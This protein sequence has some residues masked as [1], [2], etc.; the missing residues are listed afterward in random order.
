MLVLLSDGSDVSIF[1]QDI[2]STNIKTTENNMFNQKNIRNYAE[3]MK[4]LDLS[5]LEI[6]EGDKKLRLERQ[7]AQSVQTIALPAPSSVPVTSAPAANTAESPSQG[8]SI[9]SPMVGVFYRAPA[10]NAEPFVKV[11]DSVKKGDVV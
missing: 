7:L 9:T 4:E 11:G 8:R 5:A 2:R 1:I 3:L 10:E 6:T